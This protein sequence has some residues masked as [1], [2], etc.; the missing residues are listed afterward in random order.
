MVNIVRSNQN[1]SLGR[2]GI[3]TSAASQSGAAAIGQAVESSGPAIANS[4]AAINNSIAQFGAAVEAEGAKLFAESKR[5]HQSALLLDKM[6][7]A[8]EAFT[9]ARI[10]RS[11]KAVDENGNPTFGTLVQD[12]GSIGNKLMEDATKTIID[13]EVAE[14]FRM[15]FGNFVANQ[16][17]T[18]LREAAAQQVDFSRATLNKG[19]H[20]LTNQATADTYDQV[21]TY[22]NMGRAALD[23]ALA[24]GTISA[25]EHDKMSRGFSNQIRVE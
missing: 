8:T 10:E 20:S 24:S 13:P 3:S 6:A 25:V 9:A 5:S 18:A 21:G 1:P 22:D 12:V 17:V 23:D 14:Q 4:A 15:Q 11:K 16:K 19:L 7:G 2:A